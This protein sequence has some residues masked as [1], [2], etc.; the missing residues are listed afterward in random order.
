MPIYDFNADFGVPASHTVAYPN[1]N[2]EIPGIRQSAHIEEGRFNIPDGVAVQDQSQYLEEFVVP[3]FRA[4][5]EAMKAYWTGIRVPTRDNYRFM[6]VKIAGGDKSVLI[7]N[8]EINEGKALMPLA[9]INR[10]GEEFNPDKFSPPY[11][12]MTYRYLN[13]AGSMAAKVYRPT[14]WLVNYTLV[15]WAERK[16]HAEYI[17]YQVMSRFNPLAEFRM[18][19]G[20]IQGNVQLRFGGVTDASDKEVGFDQ[21]SEV[22]YEI[23]MIAEAWLPLPEKIV[24]TVMGNVRSFKEISG[25]LLE[26]N[27]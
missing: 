21:N 23:N 11:N 19:D 18:F 13:A 8:D 3:G 20:H 24:H 15:V 4:L 6:R 14:S 7:W 10:T 16:T 25:T 27:I 22:R 12:A 2:G 1:G 17:K 26:R 5:D 9:A